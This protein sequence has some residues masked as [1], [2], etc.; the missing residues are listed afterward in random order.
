V[1][2][3]E[4][5]VNRKRLYCFIAVLFV[6]IVSIP[7]FL[8]VL[9]DATPS[10]NAQSSVQETND[11]QFTDTTISSSNS[12]IT[13]QSIAVPT[14]KPSENSSSLLTEQEAISIAMPRINQFVAEYNE[15]LT[16]VHSIFLD[17]FHEWGQPIVPHYEIY[18]TFDR[19]A[20]PTND[21]RHWCTG[22]EVYVNA[23]NGTIDFEQA[24]MVI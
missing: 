19:N 20:Y 24:M 7:L 14:A 23:V 9:S 8:S 5:K 3:L 22:Y 16:G 15:S 1:E 18:A 4:H 17:K 12:S 11:S 2:N 21:S 13:N 10:D 6:A